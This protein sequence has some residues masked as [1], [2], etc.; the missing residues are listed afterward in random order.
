[1]SSSN[2]NDGATAADRYASD[3]TALLFVDPY[4]DFLSNGGK[5]WPPVQGVANEVGLIENLRTVT[6]AIRKAAIQVFIVPHRRWEPGDFED[7]DHPSPYQ[8]ASRKMRPFA[9]GT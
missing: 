5:L 7:W 2:E 4:N 1:M 8:I 9:K 3:G 6:T